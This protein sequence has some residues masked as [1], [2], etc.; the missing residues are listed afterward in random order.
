MWLKDRVGE[1]ETDE[2][3]KKLFFKI[4]YVFDI[5]QTEGED[6]EITDLPKTNDHGGTYEQIKAFII[7]EGI[8]YKEVSMDEDG[9][10]KENVINISDE[11]GID[12][13][14][15][16]ALH[17]LAHIKLDHRVRR[18][19][20]SHKLREIEAESV[21][22]VVGSMLGL[23]VDGSQLY[24]ADKHATGADVKEAYQRVV[25]A[26]KEIYSGI[27]GDQKEADLQA[28]A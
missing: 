19:E 15:K 1:V 16:I 9:S 22:Y 6:L 23:P 13:K 27:M 28:V 5:K 21:A 17:E 12:A 25:D 20:T 4:G 2:N 24:L 26:V 3:G 18:I 8:E 14:A 7:S 10:S 11:Y